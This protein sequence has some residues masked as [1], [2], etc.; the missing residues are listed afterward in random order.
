MLIEMSN[1]SDNGVNDTDRRNSVAKS[2]K[3]DN[4]FLFEIIISFCNIIIKKCFKI[5]NIF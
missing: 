1:S 4:T 3:R 2:R 5:R